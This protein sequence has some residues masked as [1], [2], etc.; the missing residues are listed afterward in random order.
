M[1]AECGIR[2]AEL[3]DSAFRTRST[4]HYSYL[5]ADIG[6]TRVARHAGM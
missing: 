3:I 6:S 1:N 2:N 5:R 4:D